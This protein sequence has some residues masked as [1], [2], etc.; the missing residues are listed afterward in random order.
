MAELQRRDYKVL[1]AKWEVCQAPPCKAYRPLQKVRRKY[2]KSR[3]DNEETGSW[4]RQASAHASL[5]P[6]RQ[7][8]Q[9][10]YK[11]KPDK[12]QHGAGAGAP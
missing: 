6:S 1:P 9:D 4:T 3:R 5:Q 10:L 2:R 11:L 12:S 7:Y 8:A